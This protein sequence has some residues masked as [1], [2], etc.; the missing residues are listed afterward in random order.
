MK[1][2]KGSVTVIAT[3]MLLFLVILC[4]AWIIMMTQEKTNALADW[5]QQQA[6]YAAEAGFKRAAVLLGQKETSWTW[7]TNDATAFKAGT[8]NKIDM[9][10]LKTIA[11]STSD[12]STNPWYA[13][14]IDR[15]TGSTY[16]GWS[17]GP[18]AFEITSVGEYM[19][20]RKVIKQSVTITVTGGG[21]ENT[22]KP[23]LEGVIQAGGDVILTNAITENLNGKIYGA[24]VTDESGAHFVSTYGMYKGQYGSKIITKIPDSFFDESKYTVDEKLTKQWSYTFAAGKTY[25]WDISDYNPWFTIDASNAAGAILYLEN[26]SGRELK[27]TIKG[28][29]SGVPLTIIV[30]NDVGTVYTSTLLQ[31]G[32]IRIIA[33]GN[34][35]MANGAGQPTSGLYMYLANGNIVT[36][37]PIENPV[38]AYIS[39][40]QNV[41]FWKNFRGEILATGNVYVKATGI[42]TYDN[43][44]LADDDFT[45]PGG[46]TE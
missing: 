40:H 34:L 25:A 32:R 17:T 10:T 33:K 29:T 22:P 5:K 21:G 14:N 43:S 1:S 42:L 18:N 39:S 9:Q 15:I 3:I 41:E 16:S 45:L 13:V 44:V 28:P 7:T 46:M 31:S 26:S 11:N 35:T 37:Q 2:Q 12:S 4:G 36:Y 19:G 27:G 38:S 20:E 30:P 8:F 23:A 24:S 6:W